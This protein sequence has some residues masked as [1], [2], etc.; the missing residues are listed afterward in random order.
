MLNDEKILANFYE[1]LLKL[2]SEYK[3]LLQLESL[4]GKFSTYLHRNY[5]FQPSLTFLFSN[6]FRPQI[7][8]IRYR[9]SE[10]NSTRNSI[11]TQKRAVDNNQK[12]NKTIR[13]RLVAATRT[14]RW[15]QRVTLLLLLVLLVLKRQTCT[16]YFYVILLVITI[17]FSYSFLIS[18]SWSNHLIKQL[19]VCSSTY[20]YPSKSTQTHTHTHR[21]AQVYILACICAFLYW[22]GI[23]EERER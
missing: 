11:C 6:Q 3:N 12:R 9:V 21:Q 2:N 7:P 1:K 13:M 8:P 17:N 19:N 22:L 16:R 14:P 20:L 5:R 15:W 10:S 23:T 18:W 4:S